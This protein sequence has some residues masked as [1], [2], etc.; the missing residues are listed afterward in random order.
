[1]VRRGQRNISVRPRSGGGA[2]A[3]GLWPAFF[4]KNF[5]HRQ[6]PGYSDHLAAGEGLQCDS[7]AVLRGH[8]GEDPDGGGGA[9]RVL[10][11]LR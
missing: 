3:E 11:V 10:S 1:M 6:R 2:P 9:D 8:G 7:Y 4:S 5:Q